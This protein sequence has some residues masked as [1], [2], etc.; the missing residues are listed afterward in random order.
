MDFEFNIRKA[1]Q[2]IVLFVTSSLL[3]IFLVLG[4]DH[5]RF[6]LLAETWM[7]VY[8]LAAMYGLWLL[9]LC[10]RLM[11]SIS[12]TPSIHVTDSELVIPTYYLGAR[13][14]KTADIY[15]VEHT[16]LK[17]AELLVLGVSGNSSCFLDSERFA[18]RQD[19]AKFR[20]EIYGRVGLNTDTYR[21]TVIRQLAQL[22]AGKSALATFCIAGLCVVIY[23]LGTT[24]NVVYP[25]NSTFPG[26][27]AASQTLLQE[28]DYYRVFSAPFV[29]ANIF[30]LGINLLALILL[31]ELVEKLAG[32]VRML[33]IFLV[34]ALVGGLFFLLFSSH[35]HGAGLSGG[36]FGLCG[37]WVALRIR[38]EQYLPGSLSVVPLH[39][40]IAVLVL[41]FVVET[42]WLENVGVVVHV[43]GFLTGFCYLFFFFSG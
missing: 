10:R 39:R 25:D 30:H 1:R 37:A 32:P 31:G 7:L 16:V 20:H 36:I 14:I 35:D 40:L 38:H 9:T 24:G 19:F 2:T 8:V 6:G 42:V 29:H 41:E 15:S 43:G 33:N 18:N 21:A 23:F 4:T 34:S 28:R 11:A 22:K 27:G 13:T 26:L 12:E 3:L 17:N 5:H